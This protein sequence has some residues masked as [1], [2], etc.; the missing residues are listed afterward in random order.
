MFSIV[1]CL[2]SSCPRRFPPSL[3]CRLAI[4]C[5]VVFLISSFSLVATLCSVCSTCCPS[6]LLYV[7]RISTFVSMCILQCQII[8]VLFLIS[9]Q[10]ILSCSFRSNIVLSIALWIIPVTYHLVHCC[11]ACLASD[12]TGSVLTL[13]GPVVT[14]FWRKPEDSRSW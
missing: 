5:M 1:F 10:G 8:F 14:H 6:F 2:L 13:T 4:F 12:V 7:R 11:L 9:E 3:L